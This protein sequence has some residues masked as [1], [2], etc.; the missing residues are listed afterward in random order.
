MS[1]AYVCNNWGRTK[2]CTLRGCDVGCSLCCAGGDV[3]TRVGVVRIRVGNK[4]GG[5]VGRAIGPGKA[6]S[7]CFL[8][9][10]YPI[11]SCPYFKGYSRGEAVRA[12]GAWGLA[13]GMLLQYMAD[14]G[15]AST[16]SSEGEVDPE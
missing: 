8:V 2:G 15:E 11:S 1:F 14:D 13:S 9:P 4:G 5:Q 10:C 7:L 16:N 12:E 6:A 3:G